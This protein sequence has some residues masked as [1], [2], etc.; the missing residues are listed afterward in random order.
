MVNECTGN[1]R[2]LKIE[3]FTQLVH[4]LNQSIYHSHLKSEKLIS[5][6][7]VNLPTWGGLSYMHRMQ[8]EIFTPIGEPSENEMTGAVE[9][10]ARELKYI[11]E[12]GTQFGEP[13]FA[14]DDETGEQNCIGKSMQLLDRSRLELPL[15]VTS[16]SSIENRYLDCI[17]D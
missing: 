14:T 6:L 12:H 8:H 11:L 9:V 1:A 13:I 3:N 16:D 2:N 15:L 17:K 7:Y 10:L 5:T 4:L